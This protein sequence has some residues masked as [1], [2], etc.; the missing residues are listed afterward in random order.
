LADQLERAGA[1]VVY[2]VVGHKTHAKMAMV[3]RRETAKDG[4]KLRRYVHLG[5]GNYHPRTA[6]LYSD[7]GLMTANEEITHDVAEVFKQL[8]GLGK[9]RTLKHLWQAP[10]TLQ[11]NVV[12]AIQAEAEAGNAT[13]RRAWTAQRV[14]QAVAA[15]W[16]GVVGS[17]VEQSDI[18]SAPNQIPL[19]QYLGG[20]AYM[21]PEQVS[22][23]PQTSA[24]PAAPSDMVFQLTDNT[25]LVVKV[26]G[27]DGVVRSTTLTLA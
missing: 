14:R 24:N 17:V 11:P 22:I 1:H 15:W 13:T 5:T 18:G 2:G 8:T 19:S 3:L 26:M 23:R 7:F 12:L 21:S 10:F 20:M 4:T 6:R 25:T 9:A 16:S 27:S